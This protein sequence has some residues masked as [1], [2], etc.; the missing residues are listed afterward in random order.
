MGNLTDLARTAALKTNPYWPFSWANRKIYRIAA[1]SFARMC[2]SYPEISAAYV[3]NSM[4]GDDWTPGSSD[5]DV[6]VI[7]K[8]GLALDQEF[9]F[10]QSFWSGFDRLKRYFPMLSDAEVLSEA[11]LAPW[12]FH[13]ARTPG[14]PSWRLITGRDVL[15]EVHLPPSPRWPIRARKDALW[16]YMDRFLP[17]L[18]APDTA[19]NRIDLQRL[20]R[21]IGR[22]CGSNANIEGGRR[23]LLEKVLA[24]L[25]EAMGAEPPVEA[26]PE[27]EWPSLP[28]DPKFL[29]PRLFGFLV[30]RYEPN[31]HSRLGLGLAGTP[32]PADYAGAILDQIPNAILYARSS[33]LVSERRPLSAPDLGS[34]F[35][36]AI[37]ILLVQSEQL[38]LED[39]ADLPRLSGV[40][41]ATS[42]EEIERLSGRRL[43]LFR[44]FREITDRI[45]GPA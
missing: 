43:E 12:L 26:L 42:F 29:T 14:P 31:L 37:K 34:H 40:K 10:L 19:V 20:A 7:V 18:N 21:K 23:Q 22:L 2:A 35:R 9:A 3:R 30:R 41:Y 44:F 36:R 11:Q 32:S 39:Y 16:F 25:D 33:D 6:T 38:T 27:R 5:I 1:A 28:V 15:A 4:A 13:I 24:V 17:A 8:P 45:K